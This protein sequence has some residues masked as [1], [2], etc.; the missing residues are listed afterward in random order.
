MFDPFNLGEDWSDCIDTYQKSCERLAE[1]ER[2]Q[3]LEIQER[4]MFPDIVFKQDPH[5]QLE[6]LYLTANK[7]DYGSSVNIDYI[8]EYSNNQRWIQELN[9]QAYL[10]IEQS[11]L[12]TGAARLELIWST[13]LVASLIAWAIFDNVR[14]LLN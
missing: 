7:M 11:P 8:M 12:L 3:V 4:N 6:K 10:K 13:A 14:S 2:V 5:E 1:A 9:E